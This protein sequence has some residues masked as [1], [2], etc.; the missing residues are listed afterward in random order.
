MASSFF[1]NIKAGSDVLS[2]GISAYRRRIHYIQLF[3]T[4][5]CNSRCRICYIWN[6]TPK[7]DISLDAIKSLLNSKVI[8]KNA[9]W[10]LVGGEF[11]LHPKYD[12]ILKIFNDEKKNYVLFSNGIFL[13]RLVKSVEKFKIPRVILSL[14]GTR[15]TY[16]KV[17]G[18]DAY[19]NVIKA[20]E[21]LRDKTEIN[22]TYTIN[23]LNS[24]NDFIHVKSIADKYDIGL[25]V[26]VYDTRS[27]FHT[28][29]K[30]EKMYSLDG[31][32]SSRY[33]KSYKLWKD[34]NLRLPC[35]S[36]R[37]NLTVKANGDVPLCQE[38]NIIIGNIYKKSIDEI[39]KSSRILQDNYKNC[40]D[41]W[42]SCYKGFDNILCMTL[43]TF[44]PTFLSKK[45][46]GDFDWDKISKL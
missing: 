10:S 40:N 28:R 2:G 1:G 23:P 21:T 46:I 42:V 8:D 41:C 17:R 9:A 32:F 25:G 4:N 3:A 29:M 24:R 31:I 45:I 44:V 18:V 16:K 35:F 13:N 34:K 12:E 39:W 11:L 30:S 33:L 22:L 36:I 37:T 7:Y 14:D 5:R 15:E 27:M 26:V 43:N 19:D 20:I 6:E 38:K